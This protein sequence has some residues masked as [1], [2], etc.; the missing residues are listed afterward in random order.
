MISD[1]F[2]IHA[3]DGADIFV[4]RWLPEEEMSPKAI[5]QISHGMA[6][7]AARYED[8][9]RALVEAGFAVY[10]NDHRGHGRTAGSLDNVGY[11]ADEDGWNLVVEDM[12]NL[13]N[14]IKE[15]H[16]DIPV[17]LFGHSMGS[18]L[19][20]CYTFQYAD[21][22]RGA[23][24]SGTG[25]DP[26]L[27]GKLGILI[28]KIE[29]AIR[30]RKARSPLMTRLSFGRFNNA[31]KPNRTEFDWLSRD[32]DQVD[33]Y[34]A[35]PFCGGVFTAGFFLDMLSGLR[36]ANDPANIG[37]TPKNLPMYIFS[38]EK[39]PVAD[40]T[41]GVKKLYELYK[42]LG[43]EKVRLKFYKDGRHEM[44]NETNKERVYSDVIDWL[45]RHL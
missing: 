2:R 19:S 14:H 44:L 34:V 32:P 11:F 5:V 20:R 8:F 40:K 35:D 41:R 23:I 30:G 21:E 12:R 37:R 17:F 26:G 39:D 36:D 9:A 24:L 43:I 10:A 33:K 31:F 7:H 1:T 22:I 45:D 38:G 42:K 18:L 4:Y 15:A 13:T 27:L 6:E 16:P 28:A 25:G 29:I 3:E